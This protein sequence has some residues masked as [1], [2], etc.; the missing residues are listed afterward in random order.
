MNATVATAPIQARV[1][2]ISE[3]KP[4]KYG[5]G[6]YNIVLFR[7][8]SIASDDDDTGKIW[9][10]LDS[11]D[12]CHYLVGDICQLTPRLDEKGKVHHDITIIEQVQTTPTDGLAP[13]TVQN[14]VVATRTGD[15]KLDPPGGPGEWTLKQIQT[16]LSRPL[17]QSLLSTRKQG[18]KDL[19]YIPWHCANRILDKYAPGWAW[20]IVKLELTDKALFL[21]GSLSIPCRDGL[22]VRSAT[23]TESL[24]CSSYGDPSSNAESM[25]FRR[26]AAKFG[27]GLNLY[28]K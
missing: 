7:D 25:A 12:A 9:K 14:T 24:D 16:A 22:I 17:P 27:L 1:A 2:Y 18:S 11:D 13:V 19:V 10:N 26:C 6:H 15:D 4:S 8:L 5:D 28:D 21:V 23:G 3:P 20:E